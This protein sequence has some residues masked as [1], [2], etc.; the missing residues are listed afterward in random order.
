MTSWQR[1]DG[2]C[3]ASQR[4]LGPLQSPCRRPWHVVNISLRTKGREVPRFTDISHCFKADKRSDI[5]DFSDFQNIKLL[6]SHCFPSDD[7]WLPSVRSEEIFPPSP[8]CGGWFSLAPRWASE[9]RPK[10]SE[11]CGSRITGGREECP[12]S[13]DKL[14]GPWLALHSQLYWWP[15][16]DKEVVSFRV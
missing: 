4:L 7:H 10:P 3:A 15:L 5:S 8:T 14:E 1:K 13:W 9:R 6:R 16:Q 2:K 11:G 12:A